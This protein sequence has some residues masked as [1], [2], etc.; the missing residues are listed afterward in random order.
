MHLAENIDLVSG[1]IGGVIIGLASTG[2][3]VVTGK[4]T[5]ISGIVENF[6]LPTADDK[7]SWSLAYL[8]GLVTAGYAVH[9][10]HHDN[11]GASPSAS[12][13]VA[14][15]GVL[16]GI[17][18]RMG[19]GCTSGH[20]ICGLPRFSLRSLV[21]VGTFMTT[22]AISSFA[23]R[24]LDESN[25]L[26][27]LNADILH[28]PHDQGHLGFYIPTIISFCGVYAALA[29]K[30]GRTEAIS[31]SR[32]HHV[33]LI[34][35]GAAFLSA[36]LFGVGLSISGMCNSD[37][38]RGFLDFTGPKG[39]DPSLMGVM[40]GGVI[41]NVISFYL[42]RH[43]NIQAATCEMPKDHERATTMKN[44]IKMGSHQDNTVIN[45]KLVMGSAIFGL[46]W[47]LGGI[48]PGPAYVNL[49]ASSAVASAF[50]PAL[51]VGIGIHEFVKAAPS[52]QKKTK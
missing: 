32:A 23:K 2:F 49:G 38:V 30:Q 43:F 8:A 31:S 34:E 18:T 52:T 12:L 44:A 25:V 26:P 20:G 48:C 50:V 22:G 3:L 45:S 51:L 16:V 10:S 35:Q 28:L 13:S 19:S 7:N 17:G 4:L 14:I 29:L 33:K 6:L 42:L 46:G 47:G 5:G 15:A 11:I 37:R 24:M 27:V 1:T 40:G 36:L 39:W 41:F 21:A 9:A